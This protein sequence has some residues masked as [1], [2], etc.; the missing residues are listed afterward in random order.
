MPRPV[1]AL[2]IDDE[3]HVRVLLGAL[4]KQLGIKTVWE[5]QDGT[6]GLAQATAHSPDIV[7]LDINL[8]EIGGLE[9]LEKLKAEHPNMP[10]VVVSAQSTVRT[11][12]RA[13]ELGA[14]GYVV[15]YAPK[16]E[17]LQNLSDFLDKIAGGPVEKALEEES[18]DGRSSLVAARQ[19]LPCPRV[20]WDV[21]SASQNG[22]VPEWPKGTVC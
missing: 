20:A 18:P 21:G 2:I 7:I 22:E 6:A 9:V 8:P 4:M 17:V 13:I 10:V 3:P 11:I 19:I 14:L 5:A 16:S 1:N 15:K 12:D